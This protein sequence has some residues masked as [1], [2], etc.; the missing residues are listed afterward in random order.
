[1]KILPRLSV[2]SFLFALGIAGAG[3]QNEPKGIQVTGIYQVAEGA[4]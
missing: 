2:F 1:M 4:K 3:A